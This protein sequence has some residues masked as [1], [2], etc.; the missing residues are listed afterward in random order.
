MGYESSVLKA[1][2]FL[3]FKCKNGIPNPDSNSTTDDPDNTNDDDN[4]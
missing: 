1:V 2:G 4:T 3:A